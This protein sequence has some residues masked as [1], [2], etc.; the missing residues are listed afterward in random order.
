M[1]GI[2]ASVE[3]GRGKDVGCWHEVARIR[4]AIT[5]ENDKQFIRFIVSSLD[6]ET[7]RSR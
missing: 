2:G 1:V 6:R 7:S 5:T 3:V 4:K